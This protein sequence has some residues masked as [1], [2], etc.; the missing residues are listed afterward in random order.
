ME[1]E[2]RKAEHVPEEAATVSVSLDGV[3][4]PMCDGDASKKRAALAENGQLT[5][6]PA[7][8][9]EVGCGTISFYDAEGAFL[10][11]EARSLEFIGM[12]RGIA[13]T[14]PFVFRLPPGVAPPKRTS[15]SEIA[16]LTDQTS[17]AQ[18]L[19]VLADEYRKSEPNLAMKACDKAVSIDSSL[20]PAYICTL[21]AC[22]LGR[23]EQAVS[24]WS[25]INDLDFGRSLVDRAV[26]RCATSRI[27]LP[28]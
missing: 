20:S 17:E 19:V 9:R 28:H 25:A 7:G 21:L 8:Y 22:E 6:G 11:T 23:K 5:R 24:F 12:S 14:Y 27:R 1:T 13:I 15:G 26:N 3:M 18:Q 10:K 16:A 2:L 4:A